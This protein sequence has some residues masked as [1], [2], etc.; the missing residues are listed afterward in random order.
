M[1]LLRILSL[2]LGVLAL[3]VGCSCLAFSQEKDSA[4]TK[5]K[6]HFTAGIACNSGLNYYGRVDSLH[7]RAIYPFVGLA[8]HNGLYMNA[9]FVFIDNSLQSHEY[10]ATLLEGGYN[11][12][13]HKGD[14]AGSFS[15]TKY[16]YRED[17]N[18]VQSAIKETASASVTKL[19][20]IIDVTLGL[21]A[22]WSDRPDAGAEAGLD[23]ILRFPHVLGSGVLV[24][25][26]SAYIYAGTQN[27]TRTYYEQQNL[28]IVPIAEQQVTTNS[29][30]FNV[31]AYEFSM[32]VV[33]GY[34]KF[35]LVFSPA[36]ILPQNLLVIPGHPELSEQGTNLFYLTV[37]ARF[38]F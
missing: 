20:K 25:D 24:L 10:A 18:L 7:S 2:R 32:P 11:F 14:W 23:H 12:T 4:E 19:S 5:G 26:P 30:A 15:L 35:N 9:S 13:D 33:Y 36:Y 1:R 38:T 17:V 22:K 34:K 27:F 16:F 3:F 6:M 28:L 29:R 31:L 8:L 21:N 37:S